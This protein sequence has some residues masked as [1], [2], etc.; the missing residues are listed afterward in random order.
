MRDESS[1]FYLIDKNYVIKK[2][3]H[4]AS[5]LYPQLKINQKCYKALM[6]LDHPCDVCP[7]LNHVK[8][9][10]TYL[11]PIRN[12]YETVDAVEYP[13]NNG[14]GHQL[15]FST[16]GKDEISSKSLINDNKNLRLL[17]VIDILASEYEDVYAY[18]IKNKIFDIYRETSKALGVFGVFNAHINFESVVKLYIENN[19]YEEDRSELYKNVSLENIKN[20][21]SLKDSFNC[22]YR[23]KR[24][25]ELHYICLH[26]A[27]IP[28]DELDEFVMGFMNEDED[29]KKREAE[30]LQ[31]P[32]ALSTK[33]NILIIDDD[34]D[35]RNELVSLLK[36]EYNIYLA[37]NGVEGYEILMNQ[38]RILSLILL[39]LHMPKMNGFEFLEKVRHDVLL[40]SVPVIVTTGSIE[41]VDANKCL[42]MGAVEV[43]MKPYNVELTCHRIRNTI[44]LKESSAT[45]SAIEYDS[46][47]GLLTRNAF[48]HYAQSLLNRNPDYEYDIVISDIE[49][50]KSINEQYGHSG[51]DDLL[52][53][54]G[55]CLLELNNDDLIFGRYSGDQFV[56]IVKREKGTEPNLDA[57]MDGMKYMYQFAP[58]PKF[59]VKFGFY[60]NVDHTLPISSICDRAMMALRSVKHQYGRVWAKF[61]LRL[62]RAIER[63]QKIVDYMESAYDKKQ[64]MVYYQPKH[65]ARSGNLVGA[66]AL[67]RWNHPE[68]GFLSP[69]EFIPVFEKNG[70]IS[71]ADHYV[72]NQV[73]Q[74]QAK[75]RDSGLSLIPVSCNMSRRDFGLDDDFAAMK[76]PLTKY[77][78]DP[79][80]VH[81][82]VT[83]SFYTKNAEMIIPRVNKLR[84][85]GIKVELDD[86]GSGYSSLGMIGTLPIDVIKLDM[87]FVR[88]LDKQYKIVELM[89][90]LAH[91]IGC[92]TVAEGVETV[93]QLD[94]LKALHCDMIQGYYYS[95]PLPHDAFEEYLIQYSK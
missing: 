49:N 60:D 7:V 75:W 85:L 27:R 86:F 12:I 84:E 19:V 69:G 3:N 58:I 34:L 56:G 89:I 50:F 55:K 38:Y 5:K 93:E 41:K 95:K 24:N 39:D 62:Q 92:K 29:I 57:F 46:L 26:I 42:D 23:I 9:P 17:S 66:E 21:L 65:D 53:Y 68:L 37:S 78:L 6:N 20:Q 13:L 82:E 67:I 10:H 33:R 15:V 73:C 88:N 45:L 72:W 91:S 81:V 54:V 64:F 48:F 22:H 8:G 36:D 28:S 31:I 14:M 74:D 25:D 70:F 44:C 94:I 63:E 76:D 79:G 32:S 71:K 30:L 4:T 90:N 61:D 1:G 2:F 35:T 40:S 77:H 43:L 59:N 87:S 52:R 83:E 80:C 47:T 51:G 16:V 11:D 18:S